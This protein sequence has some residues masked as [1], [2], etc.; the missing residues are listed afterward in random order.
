MNSATRL[1]PQL[2]AGDWTMTFLR[3]AL[4]AL[5]ILLCTSSAAVA[6]GTLSVTVS[7]VE[8]DTGVV[9]VTLYDEAA[10]YPDDGFARV[11]TVDASTGSVSVTFGDLPDGDYAISVLHDEDEDGEVRSNG[12]GIPREGVGVSNNYLRGMRRPTFERSQ[13]SHEGATTISIQ[14][15]YY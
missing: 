6:N 14:M 12:L 1:Y 4:L 10:N 2:T 13:F 9:H 7:G 8:N 11:E 15:R 5:A 3:V